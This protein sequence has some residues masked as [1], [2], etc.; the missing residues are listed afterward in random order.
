MFPSFATRETLFRAVEYVFAS[1]QKYFPVWQN[2]ETCVRSKCF[3]QHISSSCHGFKFK[4]ILCVCGHITTQINC[5]FRKKLLLIINSMQWLK[6]K[7]KTNQLHNNKISSNFLYYCVSNT[8]CGFSN[9]YNYVMVK[10]IFQSLFS[11][12]T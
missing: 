7:Q 12:K 1:L 4:K 11:I 9:V 5:Y 8:P 6:I 3:W 2:W 10:N